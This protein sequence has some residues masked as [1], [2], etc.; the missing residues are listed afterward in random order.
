M[1]QIVLTEGRRLHYMEYGVISGA[2]VIYF[3]GFPGS[4]VEFE[5]IGDQLVKDL[6]IRLISVSRP[7]YS[8]S[9]PLYNRTLLNWP[10]DVVALADALCFKLCRIDPD[11]TEKKAFNS[12]RTRD[13]IITVGIFDRMY[14]GLRFSDLGKILN[15]S[16][17]KF[18]FFL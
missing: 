9:D 14:N 3:H 17:I 2:P 11:R 7:G 12:G 8:D 6:N 16:F 18:R 4:H 13:A 5:M 1:P 10:D 15:Q